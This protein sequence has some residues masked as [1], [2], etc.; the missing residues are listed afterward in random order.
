V[1]VDLYALDGWFA[2]E[3][4]V[5]L[6]L[7]RKI[8]SPKADILLQ[9]RL[10]TLG[11]TFRLTPGETQIALTIERDRKEPFPTL[12]LVLFLLTICSVYFVPIF[13][14]QIGMLSIEM[15]PEELRA[16]QGFWEGIR[17]LGAVIQTAVP[18]VISALQ[19]GEGVIFTLALLSIL[20]THEFGHYIAGRRRKLVT[21]WPYFIPA[22]PPSVI[23]TFG[24]I[25]K[26]KSPFRNRRDL[27]EV[28]AAGP[29][30]GWIVAVIWL[31][32]G[33]TTSQIVAQAELTPAMMVFSLEGKSILMKFFAP[34]L[35]GSPPD[36]SFY[37]LSEAAFAGWVGL[38][39]TALNLIPIGSMDGGHILYGAFGKMQHRL[40]VVAIVGLLFLGF[41]SPIWWFYGTIGLLFGLTHPPT[42]NDSQ[43]LTTATKVMAIISLIIMILSFTP[44]PFR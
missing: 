20:L 39:V 2:Q 24:A 36:G 25:I 4:R 5:I 26:A 27:I 14:R 30:A 6:S 19:R 18:G 42:L 43:P 35:L 33:L 9:E 38:L 16:P 40:A 32:Y 21:S 1:Y 17:H 41:L 11:Y 44:V 12:N 3:K 23:G 13:T 22:P 34:L 8:L 7:R 10:K 15:L 29:I 28:G 31:L 37:L